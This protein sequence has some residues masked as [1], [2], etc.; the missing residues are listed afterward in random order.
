MAAIRNYHKVDDLQ[1][2][3]FFLSQFSRSEIQNLLSLGW[4]Q[5]IGRIVSPQEVLGKNL[6]LASSK[7]C[8]HWTEIKML[9]RL[10]F[11][12]RLLSENPSL[13]SSSFWWPPAFSNICLQ[14]HI[15]FSSSTKSPSASLFKGYMWL[16][17]GPI[18]IIF[19]AQDP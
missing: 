7:I 6:S 16:Q 14:G 17:L 2:K 12:R 9:A 8:Y 10:H 19:P 5:G 11:L 13:A 18:W 3:I 1:Q 4:N 15:A